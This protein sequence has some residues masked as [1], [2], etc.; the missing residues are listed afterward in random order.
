ML[1]V[2]TKLGQS[3]IAGTGLFA[4]Q[5]IPKDAIIWQYDS[6]HDKAYTQEQL[7]KTEGLD[8]DFLNTYCFRFEGLYYLC[9]DN[10]RFFNHSDNP[11]C[12]SSEFSSGNLGYT[13][14]LRDIEIGEELSDDYLGFGL[15]D[16]DKEWNKQY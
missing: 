12:Y 3:K 16:E 4:D 11:N 13:K 6:D 7:D 8:R 9:I 5:F 15:T 10:S 14:A 2:K 1:K